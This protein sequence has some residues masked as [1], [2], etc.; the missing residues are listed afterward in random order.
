MKYLENK[1]LTIAQATEDHTVRLETSTKVDGLGYGVSYRG[2][3]AIGW[4]SLA[5]SVANGAVDSTQAESG[6]RLLP[7]YWRQGCAKERARALLRYGRD[8]GYE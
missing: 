6:C 2:A 7:E 4:L 5:P 3:E 1:P 8:D